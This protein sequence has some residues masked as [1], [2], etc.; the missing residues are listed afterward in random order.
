M[1]A[2]AAPGMLGC[3]HGL[4]EFLSVMPGAILKCVHS[5][6]LAE[7]STEGYDCSRDA[8]VSGAGDKADALVGYTDFGLRKGLGT[9]TVG[10]S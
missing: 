6:L 7:G 10:I 9:I 3:F 4:L 1:L 5:V 8:E 2:F